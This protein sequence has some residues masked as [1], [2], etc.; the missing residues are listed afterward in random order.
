MNIENAFILYEH[1]YAFIKDKGGFYYS[2]EKDEIKRILY[3]KGFE[4]N[5]LKDINQL[6]GKIIKVSN[7][8]KELE[9]K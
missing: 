1:R 8:R 2:T 6:I 4:L 9:I 7:K 5:M 3:D